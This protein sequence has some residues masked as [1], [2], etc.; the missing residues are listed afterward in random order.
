M[1]Q[2]LMDLVFQAMLAGFLLAVGLLLIALDAVRSQVPYAG[3]V[4]VGLAVI[5][6]WRGDT[7]YKRLRASLPE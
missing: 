5:A 4:F 6:T 1:R 7:N 3:L 2:K